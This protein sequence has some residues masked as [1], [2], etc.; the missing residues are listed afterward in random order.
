MALMVWSDKLSVGI[1]SID[2][3]HGILIDTVNELHDAMLKGQANSLTEPLLRNLVAYTR[4]HFSAEEALM[5]QAN[6]PE[7][8]EHRAKH[9]DLTKKV[10]SYIERFARGDIRLSVHLLNFLRD[11]LTNHFQREDR[12]YSTCMN[13]SGIR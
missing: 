5:A 3:Q 11:W 9:R 8:A 13:A 2:A 1:R 4:D 7:L 10:E 12:A 6:Y